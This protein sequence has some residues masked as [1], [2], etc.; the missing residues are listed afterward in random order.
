M[1]IA[2]AKAATGGVSKKTSPRGDREGDA[3]E[4]RRERG[5]ED[6][7]VE[8]AGVIGDENEGGLEGEVLSAA[9]AETVVDAEEGVEAGGGAVVG[10]PGDEAGLAPRRLESVELGDAE[11][12]GGLVLEVLLRH[13]K[14]TRMGRPA[15]MPTK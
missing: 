13:Q 11:I 3:A 6:E 10:E 4:R 8:V 7:C 5:G 15:P 9:Y 12:G 1:T 14:S 2:A